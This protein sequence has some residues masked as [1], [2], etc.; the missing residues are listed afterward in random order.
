MRQSSRFA[1][2]PLALGLLVPAC[3]VP[4]AP[5]SEAVS[6]V[7][8]PLSSFSCGES[9]ATGYK[10]GKPFKIT[11]VHV[12]NHAVE[13]A[14]T[15]AYYAMAKAAQN[16]GVQIR[17]VSGF[18]TMA[19][20]KYL[21]ACYVNCNCNGCNLAATPGYSNHQSGHALD[22]NTSA[23]GVYSWLSNH[24]GAFGFKRTVP[25]E[26]WHWEWWGG[27]PNVAVCGDKDGDG[28]LDTKDD[29]PND[30]NPGQ[31]DTDKDGQGDACDADDDNDGVPDGK[32]NCRLVKNSGQ[33]D[34]DGDGKGN[35]CDGDDDGDGVPDAKD[36]CP[37][38]ANA[39]QTDADHDGVGDACD[40]DDGDGIA[41]AEDNCPDVANADQLDTD[42]DGVGDACAPEPD[43]QG[44]AD[45]GDPSAGPDAGLDAGP[46]AGPDA[47]LD[48]A[49]AD[50]ETQTNAGCGIE[51]R[52]LPG[53]G[54]ALIGLALAAAA[55]RRR[56]R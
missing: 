41:N 10:S 46:G 29:C 35:A 1:A 23:A 3:F 4:A 36:N 38:L 51:S 31:L 6:Q 11:V 30:K 25:S 5:E 28:V 49:P 24:A 37:E 43:P 56:R 9:T 47:G 17:V 2:L 18:R 26:I 22:L 15:N 39:D 53:N 52:G 50:A 40:D 21:Y 19:E 20:Q 44:P 7:E 8:E 13:V 16:A 55:L 12:D 45:E 33:A 14:T 48:V 34:T 27:G 32:D 42:G 54:V